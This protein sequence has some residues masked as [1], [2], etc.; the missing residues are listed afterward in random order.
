MKKES[1]KNRKNRKNNSRKIKRNNVV[2]K[3]LETFDNNY[4]DFMLKTI[5][6]KRILNAGIT[7]DYNF[8]ELNDYCIDG[9]L[10]TVVS[11]PPLVVLQK[12]KD[13]VYFL[14][15]SEATIYNG[16]IDACLGRRKY[17]SVFSVEGIYFLEYSNEIIEKITNEFKNNNINVKSNKNLQRCEFILEPITKGIFFIG[18]KQNNNFPLLSEILCDKFIGA[19]MRTAESFE[20]ALER[21]SSFLQ[22]FKI[23]VH[24]KKPSKLLKQR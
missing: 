3:I 12:P 4:I 8:E 7:S 22:K 19:I 14:P 10:A 24:F 6:E 23:Y 2:D 21:Y 16:L 13:D 11:H 15:P 1:R 18:F 20:E 5:E 17:I 9:Y